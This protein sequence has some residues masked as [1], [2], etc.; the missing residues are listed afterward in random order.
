MV[1]ID[2]NLAGPGTKL[3]VD[4]T[5]YN[6]VERAHHKPG[7]GGAFVKF[8]LKGLITGKVID[9]TVRSGTRIEQAEVS[10]SNMQFLYL[11]ADNY[12]FMDQETYEQIMVPADVVGFQSKF[13]IE[14]AEIKVTMFEGNV[15]GLELPPKMDFE[16]IETIDDAAKGNTATNVTKDAKISTGMI[17]QVPL[18]IKTG[19][20][21]R[22]STLDG[23]YV[24]RA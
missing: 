6:V 1:A 3:I 22:V 7:K 11:E 13:M 5:L 23:N 14:N 19:E 4:G 18:F 12:I 20:K 8:K 24:E 16:V 2:A 10:T 15:I 21:I 17:I 9:H